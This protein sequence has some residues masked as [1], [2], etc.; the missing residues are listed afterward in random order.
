[1]GLVDAHCQNFPQ[2]V[3][4]SR[5]DYWLLDGEQKDLQKADWKP[6][7]GLMI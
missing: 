6:A 4:D 7:A 2:F 1:M 5:A 3:G